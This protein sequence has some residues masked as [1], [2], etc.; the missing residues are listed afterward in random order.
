MALTHGFRG[1]QRDTGTWRPL[2]TETR[3]RTSY[4]CHLPH[5]QNYPRIRL[6]LCDLLRSFKQSPVYEYMQQFATPVRR[7]GEPSTYE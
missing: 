5:V 1:W 3:N 2:Q 4:A 6:V 7:R